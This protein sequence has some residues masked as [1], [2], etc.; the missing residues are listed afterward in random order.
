MN[1]ETRMLKKMDIKYELEAAY[2]GFEA[3][4]KLALFNPDLVILDIRLPGMDGFKVCSSIR[5]SYDK[6][7][8][9]ILAVTAYDTPITK[10]RILACGANEYLIKPFPGE[11]FREKVKELLQ[12]AA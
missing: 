11:I 10:D 5:A 1:P 12:E 6:D 4:R 7:R 2:D 9:K 8:V 3:G